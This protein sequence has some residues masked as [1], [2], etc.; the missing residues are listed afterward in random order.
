MPVD[1]DRKFKSVVTYM[2]DDFNSTGFIV[3]KQIVVNKIQACTYGFYALD[4]RMICVR[5]LLPVCIGLNGVSPS[6]DTG[7][8]LQT[9]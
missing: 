6:G 4:H 1:L 8:R 3:S 2:L 5:N 7:S 9:I